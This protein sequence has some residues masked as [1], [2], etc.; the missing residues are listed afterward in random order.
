MD[1][2]EM[3]AVLEI[4]KPPNGV[5]GPYGL[6]TVLGWAAVGC[7]PR[8]SPPPRAGCHTQGLEGLLSA[9]FEIDTRS[10]LLRE[11][12]LHLSQEDRL[13]RSILE[14]TTL[15]L[16]KRYEVGMLWKEDRSVIP[17]NRSLALQR[18]FSNE[19]RF[20]KDPKYAAQYNR[21]MMEYIDLGFAK[22]LNVGDL[23]GPPG[24][25]NYLVQCGVQ[26]PNKPEKLWVVF[27]AALK[28]KG[29][30]LNDLLLAGP[31]LLTSLVGVLIRFRTSSIGVSGDIEKMFLQVRVPISDQPMLR[32]VWREPG[33]EQAP[34]TYQM[35]VHIFG[36]TYLWVHNWSLVSQIRNAAID[37]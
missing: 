6:K 1:I 20:K 31:D 4:R 17:N 30:A 33:S 27:H 15:D 14:R 10:Q 29:V 5:K 34:C 36:A 18:L 9:L 11:P 8:F 24:R 22:K 35:G 23:D 2:P 37:L 21:I 16:G 12:A 26:N 25:I 3:H 32:F 19:Q 28:F 7:L 13:A